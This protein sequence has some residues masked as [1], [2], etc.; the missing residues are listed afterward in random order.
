MQKRCWKVLD[1][2]Y[3][4]RNNYFFISIVE[5]LCLIIVSVEDALVPSPNPIIPVAPVALTIKEDAEPQ[6]GL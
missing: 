1:I 6:T 4:T 3:Y 2:H 5:Y